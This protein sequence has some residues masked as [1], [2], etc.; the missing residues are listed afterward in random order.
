MPGPDCAY[1]SHSW[2]LLSG[3]SAGSLA[4]TLCDEF[5]KPAKLCPQ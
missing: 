5:P 3:S 2:K 4:V 1:N